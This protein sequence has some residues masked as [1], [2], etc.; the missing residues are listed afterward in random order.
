MLMIHKKP[1]AVAKLGGHP[2]GYIRIENMAGL[3]A[4]HSTDD[5][6]TN[7]STSPVWF[8]PFADRLVVVGDH[9]EE[10]EW[11]DFEGATWDEGARL[12]RM[13]FVEPERKP[14]LVR[15]AEDED[16]KIAWVVRERVQRSIVYQEHAVLPSGAKAR[17]MVRRD[18]SE[19]LFTQVLVDGRSEVADEPRL[20]ELERSLRDVTGMEPEE[21]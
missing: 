14:F 5:V 20:A 4:T 1:A 7:A 17:G 18:R 8:V 12:I 15:L 21:G 9:T 16:Q 6:E 3:S 2:L 13:V 19:N 10:L 11:S